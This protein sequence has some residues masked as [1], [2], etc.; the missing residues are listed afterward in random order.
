MQ[1]VAAPISAR[2]PRAAARAHR[3]GRAQ[4]CGLRHR[5]LPR[6]YSLWRR[7]MVPGETLLLVT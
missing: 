4:F 5:Y 7:L 1:S 2:A 6:L 3:P